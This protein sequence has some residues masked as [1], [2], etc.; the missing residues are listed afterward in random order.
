MTMRDTAPASASSTWRASFASAASPWAA[1]EFWPSIW[2]MGKSS[3]HC[4]H[5]LA[6]SLKSFTTTPSPGRWIGPAIA[7]AHGG[8]MQPEQSTSTVVDQPRPDAAASAPAPVPQRVTSLEDYRV[9]LD[10]YSGPLDLLLFLVKRHEIDL[11]DI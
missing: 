10:A 6:W 11:N 5:L 1:L 9:E 4:S 2:F 3:L 7:A 8:H